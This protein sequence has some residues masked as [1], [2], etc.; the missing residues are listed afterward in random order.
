MIAGNTKM[1]TVKVEITIERRLVG[2]LDA[3]VRKGAFPSRSKAVQD[4]VE[5]KL[6]RLG[7]SR[8]ARELAKLDPKAEQAMADEGLATDLAEWPEY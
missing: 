8:L 4:A 6:G 2:K 7:R 1:S 3:L 5:K